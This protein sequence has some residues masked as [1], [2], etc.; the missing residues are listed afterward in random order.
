MSNRR[1]PLSLFARLLAAAAVSAG[2]ALLVAQSAG[3]P[4]GKVA[5]VVTAT[6]ADGT[7][8]KAANVLV[9]LWTTDAATEAKR[10]SAC[11]MWLANKTV[12]MQAKG[13]AESPSGVNW[14]GTAVGSDLQELNSLLALR[15]DTVRADANGEFTFASIPFGAYTVEAEMFANNKFLQWSKDAAVIPNTTT[16]V[17]LDASTL[18]ENQYCAVSANPAA[19]SPA[20]ASSAGAGAKVYEAKDLDKPVTVVSGGAESL[21]DG[22]PNS[23]TLSFVVD[24][25]GA[26]MM[27]TIAVKSTSGAPVADNVAS[28]IVRNLRFTQPK[29]SG[30]AVSAR[31]DYTAAIPSS[32]GRRRR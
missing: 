16:R 24:A 11:A 29:V 25:T 10:D 26:P 12:W 1:I 30:A 23:V 5:G 15:R 27:R 18:A 28:G 32:G 9:Q 22:S 7:T 17:Q 13:E 20:A 21:P 3:M 31:I 8:I 6:G 4:T 2:P 14:T 19:G